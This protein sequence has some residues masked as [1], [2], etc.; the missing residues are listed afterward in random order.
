M[1]NLLGELCLK[2]RNYPEAIQA[3]SEAVHLAP[4]WWAPYQ[5][6]ARARFAA[7]DPAGGLA[8][9]EA[10]VKAT[11]APELVVKLAAV[12]EQQGRF[13]D[14]IRQYELLHDRRPRLK[15]AANNLA[16]LLVTHR[17]DRASLDRA[18][19]LSASFANSDVAAL[20]DTHGWVLFKRGEVSEALPEL[21]KASAGA[22][23]SKVILYHL[24]MALLKSGQPDKARAILEA[25][26]AGEASFT[27]AEDARIALA[28]LGGRT[29]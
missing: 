29:G 24:G 19:D 14:A 28:Q 25:A 15:L 16:M 17:Q 1:R 8:A 2:E 18:R 20:L 12:Y 11:Q 22:P 4:R 26:L 3:A 21:Q 6:L 9:Y 13:E 27:G 23:D 10:G 5:N 7:D